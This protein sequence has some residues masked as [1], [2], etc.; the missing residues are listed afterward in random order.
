MVMFDLSILDEWQKGN[1]VK[2]VTGR[3]E[4]FMPRYLLGMM[5]PTAADSEARQA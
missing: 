2:I 4:S 1:A 3:R 5:E